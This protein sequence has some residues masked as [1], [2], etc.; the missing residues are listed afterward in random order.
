MVYFVAEKGFDCF[1][2]S[3]YDYV[4]SKKRGSLCDKRSLKFLAA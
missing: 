1:K 3:V 4:P 2:K